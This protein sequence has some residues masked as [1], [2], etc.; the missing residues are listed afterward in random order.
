MHKKQ[1]GGAGQYGKLEGYIEPAIETLGEGGFEFV[2]EMVG[3]S[4]PPEYLPAIEKGFKEAVTTGPL[5]GSPCMGV[6]VVLQARA[7]FRAFASPCCLAH[8]RR[9]SANRSTLAVAACSRQLAP[10]MG[11]LGLMTANCS[12]GA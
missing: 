4:I 5:S 9:A 10:V 2:N 12:L 1:S 6:R 7:H 3:N 8:G 11:A